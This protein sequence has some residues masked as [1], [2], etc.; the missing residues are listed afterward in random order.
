MRVKPPTTVRP[1]CV[2]MV[3]LGYRINDFGEL[4]WAGTL[5]T[6]K[7]Y[8]LP[9]GRLYS[10]P[11][12]G[13]LERFQVDAEYEDIATT[14]NVSGSGGDFTVG[15]GGEVVFSRNGSSFKMTMT[16]DAAQSNRF[17]IAF[18]ACGDRIGATRLEFQT[19]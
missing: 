11:A 2:G 9:S 13:A 16:I 6:H 7:L 10:V 15:E 4:P 18:G 14:G 3:Q 5:V 19:L 8:R 12:H 1:L 17:G